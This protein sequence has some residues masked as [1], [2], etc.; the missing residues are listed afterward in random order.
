ML[1]DSTWPVRVAALTSHGHFVIPCSLL[2]TALWVSRT[3]ATLQM[4]EAGLRKVTWASGCLLTQVV[5]PELTVCR[6]WALAG[7]TG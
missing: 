5:R 3:A 6:R 2:F 4:R 1:A 7:V